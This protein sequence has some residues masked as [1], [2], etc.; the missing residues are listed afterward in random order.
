MRLPSKS[1]RRVA[2]SYLSPRRSH[3]VVIEVEHFPDSVW[4][5]LPWK[6][7]ANEN[8]PSPPQIG[9]RYSRLCNSKP[10]KLSPISFPTAWNL[11]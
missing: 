4:R 3:G 5:F 6:L 11:W 9:S 10:G 1:K 8:T 2:S 7:V